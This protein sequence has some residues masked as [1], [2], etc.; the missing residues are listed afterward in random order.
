[1][2]MTRSGTDLETNTSSPELA[3]ATV[4]FWREPVALSLSP[5][6]SPGC[7][8]IWQIV[9]WNYRTRSDRVAAGT[10]L[11]MR[12]V[13]PPTGS[14]WWT[15]SCETWGFETRDETFTVPGDTPAR[16]ARKRRLGPRPRSLAF[17]YGANPP[18][19]I[20]GLRL[21]FTYLFIPHVFIKTHIGSINKLSPKFDIYFFWEKGKK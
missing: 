9:L 15:T 14:H 6:N 13:R 7:W 19:S 3:S 8:H 5:G 11:E 17:I 1:M 12:T 4:R 21:M 10:L 18:S 16:S 2:Q 20:F